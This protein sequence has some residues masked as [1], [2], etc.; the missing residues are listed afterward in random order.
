MRL[1]VKVILASAGVLLVLAHVLL[2]IFISN[3]GPIILE[4][5][6]ARQLGVHLAADRVKF[7]LLSQGLKVK[8]LRVTDASDPN[9]KPIFTAKKVLLRF[10]LFALAAKRI[11][12]RKIIFLSPTLALSRNQYGKIT[13]PVTRPAGDSASQPP[14]ETPPAAGPPAAVSKPFFSVR[15]HKVDLRNG[16]V[17][18]TDNTISPPFWVR[19]KAIRIQGQFLSE[20]L[21]R[22][23]A[24]GLIECQEPARLGMRGDLGLENGKIDGNLD[25][26]LDDMD[27]TLLSPYYQA[28]FPMTIAHG[29][30]FLKSALRCKQGILEESEQTL[31][32]RGLKIGSWR[33]GFLDSTFMGLPAKDFAEY[34]EQNGSEISFDFSVSGPLQEVLSLQDMR[35]WKMPGWPERSR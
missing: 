29:R 21:M 15:F 31:T 9:G 28:Q 12:L 17:L 25:V 24:S 1:R 26:Q 14:R 19:M 7:S 10:N 32:V 11:S 8:N 22:F 30:L 4:R 33:E 6:L 18:F 13:L 27:I 20:T 5:T 3:K 35:N 23:E 34:L 2:W 16:E